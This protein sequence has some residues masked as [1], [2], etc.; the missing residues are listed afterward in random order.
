[1]GRDEHISTETAN[2]TFFGQSHIFHIIP[3]NFP[4][5]KEEIIGLK[6][7]SKYRRHA[8]TPEFLILD[9]IKLPLHED[10]EFIPGRTTKIFKIATTDQNQD[11]L[12]LDQENIPDGIYRIQN[13][14]ISV[15]ITNYYIQLKPINTRIKYEQILTIESRDINSWKK[16]GKLRNRLQK[17]F[18]LSKLDHLQEHQK[19]II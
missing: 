5:P 15:P 16:E 2:L 14:E 8:I 9:N 3:D 10:G 6:L 1:M 18:K 19:D 12:V 4:F 11:T 17:I 7:F 13:K